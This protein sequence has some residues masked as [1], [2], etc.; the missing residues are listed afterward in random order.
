MEAVD[1]LHVCGGCFVS[2][3][4]SDGVDEVGVY[5]WKVEFA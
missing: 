1:W 5:E 3:P 2:S 4:D